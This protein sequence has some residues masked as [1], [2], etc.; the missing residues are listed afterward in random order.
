MR[1]AVI[2]ATLT[3]LPAGRIFA[4]DLPNH[5]VIRLFSGRHFDNFDTFLEK[6]GE[7]NDPEKVFQVQDGMVHI[8]GAE[9][10]YII[11]KE[12]YANYHLRAEFKWGEAT[13]PPRLGDR[14]STRLNSS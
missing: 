11:T 3:I 10:G 12:E 1:Y 5:G 7:N 13:H 6:K 4:A 14:K 2:I 9:Y 8:S